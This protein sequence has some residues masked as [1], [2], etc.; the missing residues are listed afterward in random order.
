MSA[1]RFMSFCDVVV[2]ILLHKKL[3]IENYSQIFCCFFQPSS[4]PFNL[5]L[6]EF[7]R[8]RMILKCVRLKW[9][10]IF[11]FSSIPKI[12]LNVFLSKMKNSSISSI[13]NKNF[14]DF[15]CGLKVM[16]IYTRVARRHLVLVQ[17]NSFLSVSSMIETF[18]SLS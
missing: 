17:Y 11:T 4:I 5:I 13:I 1:S 14:S 3:R 12:I 7:L 6:C 15:S 18:I 16:L 10:S 8:L 2:D 9:D